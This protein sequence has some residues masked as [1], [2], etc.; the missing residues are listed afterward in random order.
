MDKYLSEIEKLKEE[1]K[2]LKEQQ[3]FLEPIIGE[4]Y[5]KLQT[6]SIDLSEKEKKLNFL[7][8]A[9]KIKNISFWKYL[10]ENRFI[11]IKA[12]IDE[13]RSET[14]T[15]LDKAKNV[16]GVMT[17]VA[18]LS[19]MEM[20]GIA[21]GLWQMPIIIFL[22]L[23]LVMELSCGILLINQKIN[24]DKRDIDKE[25]EEQEEEIKDFKQ[26]HKH[27]QKFHEKIVAKYNEII[28]RI[29]YIPAL[30]STLNQEREEVI[31]SF[32]SEDQLDK[33]FD[34]KRTRKKG[35]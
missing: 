21:V 35:R 26:R 8:E 18:A 17:L 34:A 14:K 30:I 27:H 2:N 28:A 15:K 9:R 25:I 33:E 22:A 29:D 32:V 24:I 23:I 16:L 7:T 11:I 3:A 20:L 5:W 6:Y 12:I 31:S 1:Q 4:I 19:A 13:M 10:K